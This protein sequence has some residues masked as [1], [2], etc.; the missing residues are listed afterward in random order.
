MFLE[1][2]E[3]TVT[4]PAAFEAA[5]AKARPLFLGSEGCLG[6]TLHRVVETPDVYRL[7]V[8]WR[9]IEDHMVGFRE[10]AVFPEWRALVSPYFA[11]APTVTHSSEVGLG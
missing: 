1:T 9:S 5:V 3:F 2:A 8:T 10:S 6:L 4:D 11:A 7:L